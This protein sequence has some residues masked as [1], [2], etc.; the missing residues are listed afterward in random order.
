MNEWM[1]YASYDKCLSNEQG[2][3]IA[4]R[5]G[6]VNLFWDWDLPRTREVF[7]R[8]QGY[9]KAAIVRGWAFT[10]IC[11]IIWME[12]STPTWSSAQSLRKG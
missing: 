4:E 8:F 5:L 2:R 10:P 11:D 12:T 6:L 3:E 1:N 9:V 7:Y